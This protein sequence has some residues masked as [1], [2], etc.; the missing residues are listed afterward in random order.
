M[1]TMMQKIAE[2]K[3]Q[4]IDQK[5]QSIFMAID[6][7]YKR[8]E[9]QS[10]AEFAQKLMKGLIE[11]YSSIG[12][13]TYKFRA[14]MA[15]PVSSDYNQMIKEFIE[16]INTIFSESNRTIKL[17]ESSFETMEQERQLMQ[18]QI[19]YINKKAID[20][21]KKSGDKDTAI[22]VDSFVDSDRFDSSMI[23][24]T[25]VN[26]NKVE[27]LI[28]LGLV[29]SNDLTQHLSLKITD[30]SNGLPGN[31][32]VVSFFEDAIRFE[33]ADGIHSN[34]K[35]MI[36]ANKDT[37]FEYETF[38]VSSD[39][40]NSKEGYGFDFKEGL[41]W[42][43]KENKLVMN[44]ILE[45]E[46]AMDANW[47]TL[48]PFIPE[49]KGAIAATIKEIIVDDGKGTRQSL[50]KGPVEFKDDTVIPFERQMFKKA[51][52]KIEQSMPYDIEVGH[53]SYKEVIGNQSIFQTGTKTRS[54]EIPGPSVLSLGLYYNPSTGRYEQPGSKD[55]VTIGSAE[56]MK[57]LFEPK[58]REKVIGSI[59]AIA[60]KR[61]MIGVRGIGLS[62]NEEFAKESEYI[63]QPIKTSSPIKSVRIECDE[64]IP[65]GFSEDMLEYS[66]SI[67]DGQS[68]NKIQPI[69]RKPFGQM[70]YYFNTQTPKSLRQ[71]NVGY[72]DSK[73]DVY[74]LRYKVSMKRPD[75]MKSSTPV[76]K[77]IKVIIETGGSD[78][79]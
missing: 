21:S 16:D 69:N 17:L 36:D 56:A 48:S 6:A 13:P 68:W 49:H 72:I 62:Y 37:W 74:S 23:K 47:L 20:L 55:E 8:G 67:D 35:E 40:Y 26:L 50:L 24:S 9:I 4:M 65:L 79:Y 53:I 46:S 31:T 57:D 41:Q 59:E 11:F 1:K 61:Y 34:P 2:S 66:I 14:A 25:P 44:L 77:E 63:S 29:K 19:R 42:I 18:S 58:V 51:Y 28:T 71:S 15:T 64:I 7:A 5:V 32:K 38:K 70:M 39:V 45:L 76:V 60:A 22:E 12:L 54:I 78:E 27:G 10:E 3:V 33:G 30:D 73:D 75:S 52:I 43:T